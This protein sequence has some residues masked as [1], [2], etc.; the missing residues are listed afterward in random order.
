MSLFRHVVG[1]LRALVFKRDV[2]RELDDEVR[3]YIEAATQEHIRSGLSREQAERV[4]RVDFGGIENAKDIVRAGGWEFSV[5]SWIRDLQYS[6]RSLRAA[7]GYAIAAV[8]I[9]GTGIALTTSVLT[10]SSTVLRQQWPVDDP[11]RVVTMLAAEGRPGLLTGGG[12][13]FR[14]ARDDAQRRCRCALRRRAQ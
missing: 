3:Q 13:V 10:V 4:A 9:L 14:R 6:L 2:D 11:A 5:E 8:G 12:E 7:P 1:G